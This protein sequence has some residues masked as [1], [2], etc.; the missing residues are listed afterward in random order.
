VTTVDERPRRLSLL[1]EI[2]RIGGEI[3]SG[4][5][6][7]FYRAT[8]WG[9]CRATARG[10]LQYYARRGVLVQRGPDNGRLYELAPQKGGTA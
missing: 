8:G 2:R 7:R 6:H 5:A 10:D 9:P 4:Q 1:A 3:T